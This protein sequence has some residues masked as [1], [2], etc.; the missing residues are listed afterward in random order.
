MIISMEKA[1]RP[2]II[3]GNWKMHKTIEE[4]ETFVRDLDVKF[5]STDPAIYIAP[6]FTA[7]SAAAKIAKHISIGAQNMSDASEGAFTGEIAG[8]MLIDAGA[9]FVILGHSERRH[10]FQESNAF[11]QKKLLR[12]VDVGLQPILCVGETLK[13]REDGK[14]YDVIETQLR[15]CL[16]EEP[17][18][19]LIIAYEPVWA[20]G[21]GKTATP[22]Q[23]EDMHQACRKCLQTLFKKEFAKTIPILYGGSVKPGN[24]KE[25]LSKPNIDGV[26]VGG[27]S[28]ILDDFVAIAAT[29]KENA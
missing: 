24:A 2:C 1:K 18:P 19:N 25:L 3:A 23:A 10:V 21:S 27:A 8:K 5:E 22:E 26:L 7:I 16:L 28:L 14:A 4:A 29:C 15:E 11:I 9:T 17:I 20:I 6:P 12:A 13:E